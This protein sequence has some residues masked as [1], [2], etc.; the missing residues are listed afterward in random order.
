MCHG[1]VNWKIR[2]LTYLHSQGKLGKK[3]VQSFMLKCV[4]IIVCFQVAWLSLVNKLKL[5]H[6]YQ[7]SF[8]A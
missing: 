7:L 5:A 4:K 3:P 8:D 2:A 1:P 6:S